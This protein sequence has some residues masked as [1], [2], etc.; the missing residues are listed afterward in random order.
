[1]HE[2]DG[3]R[4]DGGHDVADALRGMR[5]QHTSLAQ[6]K[7]APHIAEEQLTTV[8]AQQAPFGH[9]IARL[10]TTQAIERESKRGGAQID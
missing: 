5:R 8:R 3:R 6:A 10:E 7:E 2:Y 4:Y 9:E 1:M